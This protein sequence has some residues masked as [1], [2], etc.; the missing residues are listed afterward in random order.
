MAGLTL[1]FEGIEFKLDSAFTR[2]LQENNSHSIYI[3]LLFTFN[4][5]R[6]TIPNQ[7]ARVCSIPS[8]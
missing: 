7:V 5:I 8:P 6:T 2:L 3:L 1:K 4:H